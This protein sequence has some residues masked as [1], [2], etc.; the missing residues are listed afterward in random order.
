MTAGDV[1]NAIPR[2]VTFTVD[3]RTVDPGLLKSLDSQIVGQCEAA[4]AAHKVTFERE[5]IQKSEAGGQPDQLVDR[6]VH[7]IVQTAINV[8]AFLGVELPPGREAIPSGSTDA[9]VGV[10]RGIPSISV[11]RARG[12][13]QH[14]LL[15][16]ADADSARVGT[17]QIVLLAVA[18]AEPAR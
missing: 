15:E 7:P 14:T 2:E 17:K 6:R 9:N 13:E 16:W 3:L 4:A 11:G 10:V 5:Y 1:V 18:L 8:L 12:G